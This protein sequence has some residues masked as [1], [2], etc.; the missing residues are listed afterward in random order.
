MR[1]ISVPGLRILD[2]FFQLAAIDL[3]RPLHGSVI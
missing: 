2:A 1:F 3:S